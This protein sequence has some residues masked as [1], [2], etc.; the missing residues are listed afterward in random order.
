MGILSCGCDFHKYYKYIHGSRDI[1]CRLS[2]LLRIAKPRPVDLASP[3]NQFLGHPILARTANR[4]AQP[5]S[6]RGAEREGPPRG[7]EELARLRAGAEVGKE[8]GA[9][10]PGR[11]EQ[12]RWCPGGGPSCDA[13]ILW[14]RRACL[15]NERE[16]NRVWLT[17]GKERDKVGEGGSHNIL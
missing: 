15:A 6:R 8:R 4:G 9:A 16:G 3:S 13:G 12:R 7:V 17:K 5:T 10:A 11:K 1:Y 2:L 14:T